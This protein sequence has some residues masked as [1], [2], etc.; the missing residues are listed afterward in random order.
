MPCE[1][2][3]DKLDPYQD[4]ELPAQEMRDLEAHLDGC[5]SCAT[6][7]RESAKLRR[8]IQVAGRRYVASPEFRL[9]V[10]ANAAPK[11]RW[12]GFW[13]TAP[14]AALAALVIAASLLLYR[15]KE[16][17]RRNQT[18][19]ELVDLHVSTLA[20]SNPVDVASSDRHTVKPWFQ[21]RIPFT[22]NVPELAGTGFQLNGARVSYFRQAPGAQLI[23]QKNQHRI[24]VFV[25]PDSPSSQGLPEQQL[26]NKVQ[27]HVQS[28]TSAGLR[29]FVVGDIEPN[30]I[31]ELSNLMQQAN[32]S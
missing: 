18:L 12:S 5:A 11:N 32:H 1:V 4:G 26:L 20:S 15:S 23:F 16:E 9:R 27:F 10:L 8:N 31:R 22:F 17:D 28:W 7:L 29:F 13:K 24:S 3:R 14:M 6:A 21:G 2:W 19:S 30:D 25:F